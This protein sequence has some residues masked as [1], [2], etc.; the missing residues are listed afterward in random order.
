MPDD[1]FAAVWR[2]GEDPVLA[3]VHDESTGGIALL[4]QADCGAGLGQKLC[5][6]Y[7]GTYYEGRIR[8]VET[9][10]SGRLLVGFRCEPMPSV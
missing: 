5:I 8:H 10:A 4:M 3:E 7:A 2:P 1:D 6:A 9:H